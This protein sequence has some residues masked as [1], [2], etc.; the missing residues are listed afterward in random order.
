[1]EVKVSIGIAFK[2]SGENIE[3]SKL[4]KKA[5]EAMYMA[6]RMGKG[7]AVISPEWNKRE[8]VIVA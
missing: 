7:K 3:Y 5:D 4:C 2:N 8:I 1:V 6:K